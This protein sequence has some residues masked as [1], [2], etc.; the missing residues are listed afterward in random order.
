MGLA[1][2]ESVVVADPPERDDTVAPADIRLSTYEHLLHV[3]LP[4]AA[5][6]SGALGRDAWDVTRYELVLLPDFEVESLQGYVAI[7]FTTLEAGLDHIDLDLYDEF[8]INDVHI[9]YQSLAY[10]HSLDILRIYFPR[11]LQ[12]GETVTVNVDYRGTP[13]P[14]GALGLDFNVTPAGRPILATISEPFYARSWWPCKDTT[15][16]KATIDLRVVVPEDMYVAS[17]GTLEGVI[18]D[19]D[20][21]RQPR[22]DRIRELD[23]GLR[24][25]RG[26]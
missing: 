7:R 18:Y 13:E 14:A 12:L 11:S 1:V 6:P 16:D 10:D 4:T 9:D 25:A 26:C 24:L 23:R 8:T 22:G 5:D 17:A 19:G 15:T 21:A 2:G 3:G 20:R